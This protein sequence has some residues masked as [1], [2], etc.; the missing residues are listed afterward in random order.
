MNPIALKTA[1]TEELRRRK[2]KT[3]RPKPIIPQEVAA[4]DDQE[5]IQHVVAALGVEYNKHENTKAGGA[6]IARVPDD[7]RLGHVGHALV[8]AVLHHDAAG[9][10]AEDGPDGAL[11]LGA[12]LPSCNIEAGVEWD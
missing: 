7:L 4:A 6:R 11:A 2:K 9:A 10:A 12:W 8:Q 3:H 5:D 1:N